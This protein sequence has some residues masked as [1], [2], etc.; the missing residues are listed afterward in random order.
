MTIEPL[1]GLSSPTS[2]FRKTDL[3]VPDGPSITETSPGGSVRVTSLQMICLPKDLV[4]T[5]DL[6]RNAHVHLPNSRPAL[7]ALPITRGEPRQCATPRGSPHPHVR[8]LL[9]GNERA[10]AQVTCVTGTP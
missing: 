9:T 1:S 8:V 3:P 2:D 6:H 10:A 4:E 7:P 5:F